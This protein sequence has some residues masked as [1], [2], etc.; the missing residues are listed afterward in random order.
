MPYGYL[1]GYAAPYAGYPLPYPG[2]F[3]HPL[4]MGGAGNMPLS[5]WLSRCDRGQCGEDHKNFS[6][7]I[8]G[9]TAK[10]L[11]SLSDLW[12]KLEE[13]FLSIDFPTTPGQPTFWILPNTAARLVQYVKAD[14]PHF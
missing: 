4:V 12:G 9:F 6:G 2:A 10:N 13:Y 8:G 5:E 7:L 3:G 14:L 11:Y 1:G